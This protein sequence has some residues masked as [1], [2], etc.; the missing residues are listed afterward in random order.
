MKPSVNKSPERWAR[1]CLIVMGLCITATVVAE[2]RILW[3]DEPVIITLAP[4]HERI[5]EFPAP[6]ER[7]EVLPQLNKRLRVQIVGNRVFLLAQAEF[8]LT[9]SKVTANGKLYLIDVKATSQGRTDIAKIIDPQTQSDRAGKSSIE[10]SGM[11]A[12]SAVPRE[13]ALVRHAAQTLYAP[14]RLIPDSNGAIYRTSSAPQVIDFPLVRQKDFTYEL[15]GEW[16]GYGLY[17]SAILTINQEPHR[18][19]LDPRWIRG[20]WVARAMQHPWLGAAGQM[21]DRTTL[22]LLSDKPLLS[23][24]PYTQTDT[25][26]GTQR[27]GGNEDQ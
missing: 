17:V 2:D 13:V 16:A 20:Q 1:W 27:K 9:R 18:V 7:F 14:E 26:T 6:V 21:T 15:L 3:K 22:Y 25:K 12:L 4:D 5:V 19:D 24:L 11:T 10:A 23:V 8:P